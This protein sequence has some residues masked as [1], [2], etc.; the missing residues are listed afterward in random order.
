[1]Q[2]NQIFIGN[3][4]Y[5]NNFDIIKFITN[6]YEFHLV[7]PFYF[8]SYRL[9]KEKKKTDVIDDLEHVDKMKMHCDHIKHIT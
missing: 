2:T 6:F 8:L 5:S 1:M 4:G 9:Q 3:K 7:L